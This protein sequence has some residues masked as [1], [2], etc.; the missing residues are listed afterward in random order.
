M[1]L[2]Y[3][4]I[5]DIPNLRISHMG[6]VPQRE[7][8]PRTIIDYSFSG[9]NQEAHQ[10]APPEAMQFGC[11]LVWVLLTEVCHFGHFWLCYG[12]SATS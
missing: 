9:N 2:P 6:A 10:G 11:A 12:R 3:E 1:V 4:L 8:R 7:R 5:K